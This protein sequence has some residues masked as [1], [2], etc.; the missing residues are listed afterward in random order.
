MKKGGKPTRKSAGGLNV[1]GPAE[2]APLH[3]NGALFPPFALP[4]EQVVVCRQLPVADRAEALRARPAP[5]AVRAAADVYDPL[6]RTI[7][8]PLA[9][10]PA[11]ALVDDGM[12]P[13]PFGKTGAAER[14]RGEGSVRRNAGRRSSGRMPEQRREQEKNDDQDAEGH[15]NENSPAP[16]DGNTAF[17]SNE[18]IVSPGPGA[19]TARARPLLTRRSPKRHRRKIKYQKSLDETDAWD[20]NVSL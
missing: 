1:D 2:R 3:P 12:N 18:A 10:R 14:T 19:A 16:C 7:G 20:Q 8:I 6:P 11:G 5:K 4:P 9:G 13:L 17:Y 15:E